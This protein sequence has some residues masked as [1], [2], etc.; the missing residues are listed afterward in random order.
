MRISG[1]TFVRNGLE[2]DYPFAQSIRSLLPVVDEMVVNVPDSEDDT[3]DAV[4]SIDDPKL[5][6]FTSDWDESLREGGRILA[7]QTN[8]ALERCSGDWAFYL[9]ADELVHEADHASIRDAARLHLDRPGV[10]GLL[11]RFLHFE[12]GYHLTNPFRYRRQIRIVRNDGTNTSWGDACG[13][14]KTDGRRLRA[15][16][17]SASIYH[18]GWARDP[19]K[20][21]QKNRELER[22]YHDDA[23][24]RSKYDA[25]PAAANPELAVC[26]PFRGSHPVQMAERVRA[27]DWS[28]RE[29]PS[30]LPLLLRPQAW[31]RLLRKW[32]IWR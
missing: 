15:R 1:F 25:A 26:V 23:Y 10:D 31:R 30:R 14:R 21:V 16:R 28:V 3:L 29:P 19:Q 12:G 22:L 7:L 6:V 27:A 24:I 5:K 13:F 11:F 4:R 9:Q 20:L 2:L 32:R 8:R 18:Y 17:V